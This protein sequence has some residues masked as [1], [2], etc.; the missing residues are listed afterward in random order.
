MEKKKAIGRQ[1]W[2]FAEVDGVALPCV[3]KHWLTGRVY[4][5]PFTRHKGK[6]NDKKVLEAVDAIKDGR[7]VIL[8]DDDATLD[9]S[10]DVTA[11]ARKHYIAVFEVEDVQYS[12]ED[13]LRFRLSK[14]LC[15]LE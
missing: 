7:H 4:H 14:R 3:H 6:N 15:H 5:D 10:G 11:F 12:V 8:T 9:A 13:G 1:G 2:W